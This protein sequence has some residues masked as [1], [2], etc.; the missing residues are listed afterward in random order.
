MNSTQEQPVM[1][2]LTIGQLAKRVGVRTSTLRYYEEQ[3]LLTPTSR[4]DAGYRLYDEQAEQN[5]LF[6]QRAQRLGFLLSDIRTLLKGRQSQGL[7][8]EMLLQI[9]EDRYLIEADCQTH[10]HHQQLPEL[11]HSDQGY[12]FIAHGEHAFI[13]ARLLLALERS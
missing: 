3:A 11:M 13:F 1:R 4:S 8:D 7:S 5:L 2:L 12:L 10:S 6:I 9:A